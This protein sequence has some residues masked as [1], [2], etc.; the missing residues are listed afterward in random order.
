MNDAII[1]IGPMNAGKS[2]I[3]GLLAERTGLPRF[4]MDDLRWDYYKELGYDHEAIQKQVKPEDGF[5]G[6]YRL[7]KPF[8]IHAVERILSDHPSGVID[9]GAG[10]SVYEDDALFIRASAALAPFLNVIL[11]LPSPDLDESVRLLRERTPEGQDGLPAFDFVAHFVRHPSNHAL[12]KHVVYTHGKTPEETADDV[13][14]K[15]GKST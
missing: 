5:L 2:T 3:A 15:T 1:L 4:P 9:F 12:A 14:E 11:L 13:L 10:H 7:W 6:L 8:E